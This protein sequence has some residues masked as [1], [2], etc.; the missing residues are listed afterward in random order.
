MGHGGIKSRGG[1]ILKGCPESRADYI[2]P[3][4]A[5]RL[6]IKELADADHV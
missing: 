6:T 3:P 4:A 5:N 2:A 1:L